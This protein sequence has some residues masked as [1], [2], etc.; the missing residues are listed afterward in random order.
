[1]PVPTA[2][3]GPVQTFPFAQLPKLVTLDGSGSSSPNGAITTY[4][5]Y[6]LYRP[7]GSA[8][9]LSNDAIAGP[10][11]TADVAGSYLFFLEVKD[12]TNVWSERNPL[13][14]PNAAFV[15]ITARTQALDLSL[16]AT[17]QRNYTAMLLGAIASLESTVGLADAH[18]DVG[19][20]KHTDDQITYTRPD[21]SRKNI[22]ASDDDLRKAVDKLDDVIAALSGLATTDKT[23][24]VA[25]VNE[26]RTAAVAAK[27][28]TDAA[29]DVSAGGGD[30]GK[31]VKLKAVPGIIDSTIHG[32]QGGGT[33]HANAINGGAAGFMSGTDKTKLDNIEAFADVTDEANVLAALAFS[34]T[35]KDVGGGKIT[36]MAQPTAA[37]EGVALNHDAFID[38][39]LMRD[40]CQKLPVVNGATV[41]IGDIVEFHTTGRTRKAPG[42]SRHPCGVALQGGTGDA[43]GT[44]SVKFQDR[45]IVDLVVVNGGATVVGRRVVGSAAN[46]IDDAGLDVVSGTLGIATMGVTGDGVATCP[47]YLCPIGGQ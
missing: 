28:A 7:A 5:W 25:A 18:L 8:A 42:A 17:G 14:A 23:S 22:G 41:A 34:A 11:F 40:G 24:V 30:A 1:M 45:G 20:N 27:A 32:A 4:K 2:N 31:L 12:A 16:P 33:L 9:A 36:D 37:S 39:A 47:V 38:G 10:T 29:V 44:V 13:K 19:A 46:Q 6:R 26:V 15:L 35:A 3:A 21:G 43:G